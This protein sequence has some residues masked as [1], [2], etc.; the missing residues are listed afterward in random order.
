MLLM[1]GA[2]VGAMA[3]A[4]VMSLCEVALN[5]RLVKPQCR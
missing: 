5:R 2:M 4:M 1:V 3:G